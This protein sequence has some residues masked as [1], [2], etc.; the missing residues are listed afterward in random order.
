MNNLCQGCRISR[1]DWDNPNAVC[2]HEGAREH[3]LVPKYLYKEN[4]EGEKHDEE[5]YRFGG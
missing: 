3:E 5:N 2:N 1:S 4:R